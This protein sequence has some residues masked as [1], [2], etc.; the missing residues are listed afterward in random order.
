MSTA[1]PKQATASRAR[2]A[3]LYAAGFVTAFGAH[4][5]AASLGGYTE[6][7]HASLLTLG[8]LLAVYDG[9]EVLLKPVFGSLSDR[10]GPRP[11]LLG[12]L[13]AFTLASGAFVLAGNPAL[14]GVARLGQ[15]AAAAAFSPAAGAM[16]ARLTPS[17]AHGRAFGGYG[18][19]KGLGYTLGPLLGG[20]LV[21]GG[22]YRLLFAALAGL[23]ALVAIWAAL[24]VPAVPILPRTRQTVLDLARRLSSAGFLRPTAALAGATAALAVGVGF[25]PVVGAGAGLGPL[26]TG[27]AVSLLAATAAL[28]QPRV[29]RAR[30]A[31]RLRDGT[32]MGTGLALAALGTAAA[33]VLPPIAAI[34]V[35]ALLIGAGTGLITPLGFAY[36]AATAPPERLGQTMGAA[37]VG[38]ELGDAGGPLLV[39][40]IATAANLDLG[41]LVLA[42]LL[43][44]LAGLVRAGRSR[45]R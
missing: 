37:E 15:G 24:A 43:V 2:L 5:I 16:V 21:T 28:V 11:V 33:T 25:L 44:V 10:I 6:S 13:I 42:V 40:V 19:W 31:G 20:V 26:A 7:E 38:R 30:D 23:A 18:A 29:G 4:S 22:G 17:G 27:A 36:L 41:L 14:V 12:G 39:G 45:H 9:A 3:P 34:T 1:S 8:L 32:G 35:G